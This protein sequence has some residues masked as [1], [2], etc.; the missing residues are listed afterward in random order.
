MYALD[1]VNYVEHIRVVSKPQKN[2]YVIF[3]YNSLMKINKFI[4]KSSNHQTGYT[5]FLFNQTTSYYKQN[6]KKK[7]DQS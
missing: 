5:F 3:I 1:V 4:G 6:V 7:Y 2:I